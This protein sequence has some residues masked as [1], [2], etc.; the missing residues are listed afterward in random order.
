MGKCLTYKLQCNFIFITEKKGNQLCIFKYID[1]DS[2][3]PKGI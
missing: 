3:F 2:T 1:L